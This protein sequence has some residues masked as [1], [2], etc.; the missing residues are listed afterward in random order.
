MLTTLLSKSQASTAVRRLS[1]IAWIRGTDFWKNFQV[2]ENT[3]GSVW[4]RTLSFAS[5]ESDF[6]IASEPSVSAFSASILPRWSETI[7]FASPESDFC[8]PPNPI[9]KELPHT[10]AQ[11]LNETQRAV[12]VTTATSPFSV[13]HVNK[14]WEN[15]CGFTKY[16]VLHRPLNMI[17]GKDTN[18]KLVQHL[19]QR[20]RHE[21]ESGEGYVVNYKADGS[22][23]INHL[24]VGPL[25]L[26]QEDGVDF[27]V[28]ILEQVQR[29]EVPLRMIPV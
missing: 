25:G 18:T 29:D 12:V 7:S 27:L 19:I 2:S 24:S 14:A 28:G 1:T 23:F 13:V 11:A 3:T 9:Q 6:S 17:Q 21:H 22:K 15:L 4:S 8:G 10:L 5:P 26:D 20:A 16:Q